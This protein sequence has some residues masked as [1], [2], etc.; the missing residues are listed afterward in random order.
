MDPNV[1][2][3]EVIDALGGT[4]EV[5]RLCK[6]APQAVTQW[7]KAGIPRAREMYLRAVRPDVWQ[8]E[9]SDP[10]YA[11]PERRRA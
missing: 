2:P 5:A 11:G 10:A 7:R 3:N 1:D 4:T 8:C 9:R 6:V